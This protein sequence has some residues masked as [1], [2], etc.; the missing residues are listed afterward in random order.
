M[1]VHKGLGI[2][3]SLL[4]CA[5]FYSAAYGQRDSW[6][7][8]MEEGNGALARKQFMD[9]E[10]NYRQAVKLAQRFNREGPADRRGPN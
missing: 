10:Q 2:V 3:V 7:S 9:A 5:V 8:V 1:T 4:T 6:E